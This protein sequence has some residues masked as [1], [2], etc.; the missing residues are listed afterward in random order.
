M[1]EYAKTFSNGFQRRSSKRNTDYSRVKTD[2]SLK[3][4]FQIPQPGK[5]G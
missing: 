5:P 2:G 4:D 3:I 1:E